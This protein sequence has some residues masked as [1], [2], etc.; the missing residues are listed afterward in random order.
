MRMGIIIVQTLLCKKQKNKPTTK[1]H[2][3]PEK[4]TSPILYCTKSMPHM[5]SGICSRNSVKR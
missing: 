5:C 3:H 4:T 1:T 2:S